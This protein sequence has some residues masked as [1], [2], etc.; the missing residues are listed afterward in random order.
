MERHL[1]E[2]E[3]VRY[4]RQMVLPEIGPE[5]Q[6]KLRA[7]GVLLVGLGG[8]GCPAALYLAAAGIG[9]LGL[10][11]FDRVDESNLQ[12]QILYGRATRDR[13]KVEAARERLADL[14]PHVEIDC[15]AER[16]DAENA[17]P[18]VSAYDVIVDG[19]DNFATRYLVNDACV[20]AGKPNVHGAIYRFEGRVAVFWPQRGGACY[21]CLYP[22]PPPPHAVPSCAEAGVLG[23]L[24]GVIG[25]LQALET[26][27]LLLGIGQ[28]MLNRMIVFDALQGRFRSI[29]LRRDR[30]CPICG[31][32][33]TITSLCE[34]AVSCAAGMRQKEE[35][36]EIEPRLVKKWLDEGRPLQLVDVREPWER[37]IAPMPVT[38][39][40]PLTGCLT[41][42]G[43][44][45]ATRPT[46]VYCRSGG[47]SAEA[48]R[49]L[50]SAGFQGPLFNL[51]GGSLAWSDQVD[52][53]VPKY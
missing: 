13:L 7:A 18:L 21:R 38:H 17:L 42:L 20:L 37:A 14:N 24:P 25:S 30:A 52:P 5:G 34:T 36:E 45:D 29:G 27:K 2:E 47:R 15:Y 11:D 23:A 33:P 1:S 49:R 8:L 51:R 12:R 16:F 39:A 4:A 6:A 48:I 43:E 40:T 28:P 46:V 3:R 26:L 31:D 35:M 9:R 32:R 22:Q 44:L 41:L 50:R 53:Q 10:V 19:A